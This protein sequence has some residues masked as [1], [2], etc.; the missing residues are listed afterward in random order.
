MGT[1]NFFRYKLVGKNIIT[2]QSNGLWDFEMP[3][4]EPLI[5][6]EPL[7]IEN[8]AVFHESEVF[9]SLAYYQCNLGYWLSGSTL[10]RCSEDGKWLYKNM[11]TQKLNG[12]EPSCVKVQCTTPLNIE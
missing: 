9:M 11:T 5:C 1:H 8:G 4:C 7:E 12:V 2:C 6:G 10:S 3:F